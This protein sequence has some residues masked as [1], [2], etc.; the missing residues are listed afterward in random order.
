MT[1]SIPIFFGIALRNFKG[2]RVKMTPLFFLAREKVDAQ[3][4]KR[5]S[6]SLLAS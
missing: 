5:E 1:G 6:D 4:L 3:D 2:F